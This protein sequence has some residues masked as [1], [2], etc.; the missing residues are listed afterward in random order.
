VS[1]SRQDGIDAV[2][3]LLTRLAAGELDARGTR[4]HQ[5]EDLDAIVFGINMLAEELAAHR[6]ELEERVRVRTAEL[7]VARRAATE[8]SRMKS[9]FLATMSHEI[10]TPMNG[11]IGLTQ[12]LGQTDLVGAQ[13]HYVDGLQRAGDALLSVINDVLDFSKLEAD[14]VVLEVVDF[15][16]R[17]LVEKIASLL[18]MP[19][20]Q[21][22]IE[23]I[24]YCAPE[25]PELL[26]GDEGRLSQILLNL[27]ANAVKFTE[28]GEVVLTASVTSGTGDLARIRFEVA[29]TGIGISREAQRTLFESFTQADAST[30]RQFGGSGLGLAISRKLSEVM[31]GSIGVESE[32]GSGSTFWL[33]VP[34]P[35]AQGV[36]TRRPGDPLLAG[37]R[38]LVVEDNAS[39]QR[40]L[41]SQLSAWGMRADVPA[42]PQESPDVV[43]AALTAEDPY[44]VVIIDV[45]LADVDGWDLA[46]RVASDAALASSR[47][48]ILSRTVDLDPGRLAGLGG[49]ELMCKPILTSQLLD[50]LVSLVD[51]TSGTAVR[52][53]ASDPATATPTLGLVLVVEDNEVNQM[54]AEGMVERLGYEV[55][56]VSNG[57]EAVAAVAAC[58]YAA[59]LM[60]CHMPVMDGFSATAQIRELDVAG[61]RTPVI[62]MTAGVTV[63]ERRRCLASGMDAF[64]SKPVELDAL[65]ETLTA[66]ARPP[67]PAT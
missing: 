11:V 24:A 18:A 52:Q 47:L 22:E 42:Q 55:D 38:V 45:D 1:P 66:W 57:L 10:R 32:E 29:D 51:P 40:F 30:T 20:T 19:A 36:G 26:V 67:G 43:L 8:A 28:K 15:D 33:E 60:D 16:P 5:D 25:V 4:N 12:L 39:Y 50:R 63:E 61:D 65:R 23:L 17:L 2:I 21:K 31:D 56:V 54:V 46:G 48:L 34:L 35:L 41:T 37:K 7:E 62:A 14:K 53:S 58:R 3:D 6:D 27:A 49:Q 64:V 9:E 13:R 44:D 59:V